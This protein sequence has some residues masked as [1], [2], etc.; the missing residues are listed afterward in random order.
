M[1]SLRDQL[2]KAGLASKKDKRRI[3]REEKAARKAAQGQ[4]NRK[5]AEQREREAAETAAREAA[6][7]DK[8]LARKAAEEARE[9]E[10]VV[11]RLRQIVDGNRLGARG[12]VPFRFMGIDR[13]KVGTMFTSEEMAWRLRAG[14]VGIAAVDAPDG[15]WS[16]AIV[17]RRAVDRLRELAPERVVFFVDDTTGISGP[18]H[19][20]G[21]LVRE[22]DM[23]AR[24]ATAEDIARLRASASTP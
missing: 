9:A 14:Q 22:P 11:H 2:L 7:L 21:E 1:G 18:D 19:A 5:S 20:F 6:K 8:A 15:A 17:Q 13:H 10:L 12:P 16:Y 3:D 24:R 23:R 4:R